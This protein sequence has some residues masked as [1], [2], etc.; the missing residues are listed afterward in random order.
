VAGSADDGFSLIELLT[1]IV[2]L[3]ILA[4]IALPS[5]LGQKS[6]AQRATVLSDLRNVS[7]AQEAYFVDNGTYTVDEAD[8]KAQGFSRSPGVSDLEITVYNS[9]GSAAYCARAAHDATAVTA[10]FSSISGNVSET[11]PDATNC[12][13]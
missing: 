8:L 12:P 10:W 4:A 7:S 5:F 9:G 13:T 11:V 1:V 2:I 3:G 6:R